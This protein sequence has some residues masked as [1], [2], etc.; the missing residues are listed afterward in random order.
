MSLASTLGL[1]D[2]ARGELA[3]A[4]ARWAM[5]QRLHPVLGVCEDLADLPG[6]VLGAPAEEANRVLLALGELGAV[7]GGDDPAATSVLVWLLLPGAV[8]VAR[9]LSGV[10][11]VDELVGAQLWMSARSVNWRARVRVA[12][13]V[14]M[15]TRRDVVRELRRGQGDG[16]VVVLGLVAAQEALIWEPYDEPDSDSDALYDVLEG[17]VAQ[18]V[19]DRGEVG[20]LLRLAQVCHSP[21]V[22]R[23]NVGLTARAG[24]AEVAGEM[25]LSWRRSTRC[26]R[27]AATPA[28]SASTGR[29]STSPLA[30]SPG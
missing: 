10:P 30:R 18:G 11:D 6:W 22:G 4:A 27:T 29:R 12:A 1:E 2:V 23:G 5:W 20:V 28:P 13:T 26:A 3:T 24:M 21:R 19:V 8:G 16:R 25:G 17:A 7:D 15:N 9:S 14:L